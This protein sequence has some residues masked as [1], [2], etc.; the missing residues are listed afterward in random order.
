MPIAR[1]QLPD[2]RIGRFEVPE[3]TTPEQVVEF[4]K[5][6]SSPAKS[7]QPGPMA[8]T[9][10]IT[11]EPVGGQPGTAGSIK[12]IGEA[13][14][15]RAGDIGEMVDR[16]TQGGVMSDIANAPGT[17]A[18]AAGQVA[19]GALDVV[20]EGIGRTLGAIPKSEG[21]SVVTELLKTDIGQMG[22]N[23]AKKGGEYWDKFKT[24]YPDAAMALEGIVN[25]AGVG[26]GGKVAK[27]AVKEAGAVGR[28]LGKIKSRMIPSGID[29]QIKKTVRSGIEKAIRPSVSGKGTFAKTEAY[30]KKAQSA[31]ES[32][33]K[34]K[35]ILRLTDDMGDVAQ[36][37][38]KS[39]NQFSEA[40]G[41]TKAAIYSQY[42][43]L[44]IA[45]GK[46]GVNVK[47]QPI[48]RE[49]RAIS[50][51]K[52]VRV[53]SPEIAKY[54]DD[55]STELSKIK[56]YSATDAQEAIQMV[57]SRLKPF[58]NNPTYEAASKAYIDSLA[59]NHIRR[60]LDK[61]V[62]KSTGKQ[63]SALKKEYGALKEIEKDITRR[64][65][66]DARKN[67]KGLIDMSDIFSGS[68][69][70][71]GIMHMNPATVG[72]GVSAK[73]IASLQ[74]VRN[75]PNKIVKAMFDD[76]AKLLEKKAA[77]AKPLKAES[78]SVGQLQRTGKK[79]RY[80]PKEINQ[81]KQAYPTAKKGK[82]GFYYVV[83]D[84]VENK[85]VF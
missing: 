23:A 84:G 77:L 60:A 69:V 83:K 59:V 2:G 48:A 50:Q 17:A 27:G 78:F 34:N 22:V 15:R 31:V 37:L 36:T 13:W 33:I 81:I 65:V 43:D 6:M 4:A 73:M 14:G 20:G 5:S 70:V 39:L 8:G 64:A 30:F 40:V 56:M 35:G 52:N 12:N 72:A 41:Q 82:D 24:S 29:H 47:L 44:A 61:A 68:Q 16:R 32:I 11:G 66:V 28:D 18:L 42:D 58:Y 62:T 10:T 74:K 67:V 3:G 85:V 75:D 53:W 9:S 46:Q 76:T 79:G 26:A 55:L 49:L 57:N 25:I 51:N 63:Y 1:V 38:P 71:S 80:S 19:G 21:K 7:G 54:A 45:A